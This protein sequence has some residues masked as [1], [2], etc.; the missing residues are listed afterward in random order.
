[1]SNIPREKLFITNKTFANEQ[2]YDKAREAC[3][4]ILEKLDCGYLDLLLV[5]WPFSLKLSR[6]DP[7]M[8]KLDMENL[9]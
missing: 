2:G 6:D 9:C 5:H 1:V 3:L 7:K 8:L 4:R